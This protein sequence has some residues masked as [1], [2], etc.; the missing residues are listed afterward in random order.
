MLYKEQGRY[1][2]TESLLLEAAEGRRLRLGDEHPR[3]LESW[4]NLIELYEAWD[5]PEEAEQR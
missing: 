4:N 5:K 1:Q 3:I 2:E